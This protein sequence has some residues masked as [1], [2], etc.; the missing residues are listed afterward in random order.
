MSF[1]LF[2][3][4]KRNNPRVRNT[5]VVLVD[6]WILLYNILAVENTLPTSNCAEGGDAMNT[7]L[8]FALSVAAN[9]SG[10]VIAYYLCKWLDR[11]K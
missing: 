4:N 10:A 7:L 2:C 5:G 9:V 11:K 6:K 3:K 1:F 8:N